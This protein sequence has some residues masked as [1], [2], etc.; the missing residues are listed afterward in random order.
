MKRILLLAILVSICAVGY[1]QNDWRNKG[2]QI[3]PPVC[4]GSGESHKHFTAPPE[5]F[6][7]R[8]KSSEGKKAKII[9]D[10][11]GFS[12]S[13]KV[14]F[15]YAVEIWESLLYSP[16]PIHMLARWSSLDED[17]LGSCGP[18]LYFENFDAAH[19]KDRYYPI[20]LVEKMEGEEITNA[21]TPDLIAQFNKDFEDWYYGIDGETPAGKYDFVSVVLHEIAHGLGFTGFFSESNDLGYYGGSLDIP[22][23]FDEFIVDG[24]LNQLVDTAHYKNRSA[25]LLDALNGPVLYF[26]S[27]SAKKATN[28]DRAPRLYS[29]DPFDEGSSI[30]HL[31][32]S[33][34]T[35][36]NI[37]SLMTPNADLGA[38]IHDPGPISLGIFADMGWQF[39]S[40]KHDKLKDT[41]NLNETIAINAKVFSDAELDT[42]TVRLIYT[43]SDFETQA[44]SILL[45]Y[46]QADSTFKVEFPSLEQGN[47]KY[48]LSATDVDDRTYRFPGIAPEKF[49][50]FNIGPDAIKPE[51]THTP[52]R[53]LLED[54]LDAEF[55]ATITDNIGISATSLEYIVNDQASQSIVLELDSIDTYK[56]NLTFDNLVNGDSIRYRIKVTDSSSNSNIAYLPEED[57][58]TIHIDGTLEPVREY[59]TDLNNINNRD[60]I[61]NDFYIGKENGFDDGA[62]HSPHPYPSPDQD[63]TYFEFTALL[64]YPII[65]KNGGKMA[66]N[67]IVL[68]EPGENNTIYTD[69]EFWD[70]V[71]V[72]GSKDGETN[73]LPLVDGYDS[74]ENASWLSL[75]NNSISG[76]NSTANGTK[77]LFVKREFQLT[78]S[79]HFA[80][81]DTIFIRFRIHSDPY[82]HGW[83]WAIDDLMIQDKLTSNVAL[84]FSPGEIQIYPNP[85]K[86]K[87]TIRADFKNQTNQILVKLLS[88]SG[89]LSMT[90]KLDVIGKSVDE[91]ISLKDLS[92]GLYLLV[93]EFDNGQRITRKILKD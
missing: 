71:I 29:P 70:Y 47:I 17:V 55:I 78:S 65:I 76:Q 43:I 35:T 6:L 16:V 37:N 10:Y 24:S 45:N 86:S 61:S 90:K 5:A 91:S 51:I 15:Q 93:L 2:I 54:A 80:V 84:D 13:A 38:A 9:V 92:S 12:D 40:I 30:Y 39:I 50:D 23:I 88:S 77:S 85:V 1:S 72:E 41:E 48:Y 82:A 87:L 14:A 59:I 20:A 68:V 83:G 67:E 32:E 52:I 66:F 81:N 49:F 4:Y 57:F 18:S 74:K 62:L 27:P 34:F 44:D 19:Y 36:G 53:S 8:L 42:T 33:T 22:G 64:K 31:N 79:N 56:V 69:D 46:D 73:W 25:E 11:I 3:D 26:D 75:Y 7:K 63:E 28:L 58:F 21:E 60:F 89:T